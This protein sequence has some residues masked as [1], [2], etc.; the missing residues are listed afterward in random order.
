MHRHASKCIKMADHG[1]PWWTIVWTSSWNFKH[2]TGGSCAWNWWRRPSAAGT[3]RGGKVDFESSELWPVWRRRRGRKQRENGKKLRSV[4]F[5][6][7]Q[8]CSMWFTI[9]FTDV[10]WCVLMCIDVSLWFRFVLCF[11]HGRQPEHIVYRRSRLEPIRIKHWFRFH[12]CRHNYIA[13]QWNAVH[14]GSS[15]PPFTI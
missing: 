8:W 6:Y 5:E 4:S 3:R 11:F 13:I 12:E 15:T 2:T 1:E 14:H 10:A 9:L 7:V